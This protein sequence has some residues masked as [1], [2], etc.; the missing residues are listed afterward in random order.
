MPQHNWFESGQWNAACDICGRVFKSGKLKLRWDNARA[1]SACWEPRH[2]QDFIRGIPD[3]P[4][5]PWARPWIPAFA[6]VDNDHA[7][8]EPYLG[9]FV[10]GE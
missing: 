5:V 4:S 1:C 9:E 3:D 10:L 8:G 6:D 7:L 2:P